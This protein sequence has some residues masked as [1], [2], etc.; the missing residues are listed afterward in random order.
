[1]SSNKQVDLRK[2][3][4]FVGS[5]CYPEDIPKD[6]GKI[7]NFKKSFENL[8]IANGHVTCKGKKK[9]IPEDDKKHNNTTLFYRNPVLI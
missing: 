6:K 1:M 3:G 8:K 7:A 4:N 9:V 2:I 5:K